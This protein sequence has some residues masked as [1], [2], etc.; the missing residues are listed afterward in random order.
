MATEYSTAKGNRRIRA[1]KP[2]TPL[3]AEVSR[4]HIQGSLVDPSRPLDIA[5]PSNNR[6]IDADG[7]VR[8]NG[9]AVV[10]ED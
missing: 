1:P 8:L 9:A 10:L 2:A 4:G 6:F 5:I 7:F 3:G